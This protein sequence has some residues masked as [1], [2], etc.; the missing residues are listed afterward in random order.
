MA[1]E[2]FEED[3]AEAGAGGAAGV[4]EPGGGGSFLQ[5]AADPANESVREEEGEII[6]A[7]N[8]GV[9]RFRREPGEK[10]D[11]RRSGG[12]KRRWVHRLEV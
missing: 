11:R 10:G 9:N 2:E 5:V 6:E 3:E 4:E 1:G 12:V 8:S 7:E